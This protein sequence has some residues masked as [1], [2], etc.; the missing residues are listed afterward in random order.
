[1]RKND[2]IKLLSEIKGNPEVVLWNGFV[3]D[4]MPLGQ[5]LESNL[6]KIDKNY[7]LE[8]RRLEECIEFGN[9]D[10]QLSEQ[11]I[12]DCE[13]SYNKY[14]NWEH[15]QFVTEEDIKQKRYRSKRVVYIEPK[16]RGI[17]TFDRLGD[18]EY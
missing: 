18:I 3:E 5:L 8:T 1:M 13:K 10:H 9:W 6:V 7:F 12:K 14:H 4:W 17:K 11:S 2:L 15:N 16:K